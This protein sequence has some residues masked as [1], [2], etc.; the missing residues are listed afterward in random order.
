MKKKIKTLIL[1]RVES[2]FGCYIC[3][4]KYGSDCQFCENYV[5]GIS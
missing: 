2:K 1:E 5:Y 4:C 3:I